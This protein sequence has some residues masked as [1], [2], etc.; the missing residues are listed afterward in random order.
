MWLPLNLKYMNQG[1]LQWGWSCQ[2]LGVVLNLIR[3][4]VLGWSF[5]RASL[6]AFIHTLPLT[7]ASLD[8]SASLPVPWLLHFGPVVRSCQVCCLSRS[9]SAPPLA[10]DFIGPW[11]EFENF[12]ADQGKEETRRWDDNIEWQASLSGIWTGLHERSPSQQENFSEIPAQGHWP[13][14]KGGEG[15]PRG[16]RGHGVGIYTSRWS[17]LQ[18][19]RGVLWVRELRRE[20]VIWV[21]YCHRICLTYSWP[22]LGAASRGMRSKQ[23]LNG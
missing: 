23:A 11:G 3:C 13:E 16:Q 19:G 20:A 21:F 5:T 22:M 9:S 2:A 7:P 18:L 1:E 10:V 17:W 15:T 8:G 6:S 4:V 12:R 14:K